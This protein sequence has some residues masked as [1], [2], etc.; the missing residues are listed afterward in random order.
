M[1]RDPGRCGLVRASTS[2]PLV[3]SLSDRPRATQG[4]TPLTVVWGRR[5][6]CRFATDDQRAR[7]LVLT[8]L[9]PD[10]KPENRATPPPHPTS[11]P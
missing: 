1:S 11:V 6:V 7:R 10:L 5:A 8:C 4:F 2:G 9:L 3:T